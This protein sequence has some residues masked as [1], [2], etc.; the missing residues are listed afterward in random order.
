MDWTKATKDLSQPLDP[1]HVKPPA[2]GKYGNY[3][4]GWHAIAEANRIFGF[5][6]WSY[7]LDDLRPTN[8]TLTDGKHHVGYFARVTVT[9]DGTQRGDVGHGQGHGKS[10]GDAHDS[11]VK[12]AVTD[13]LKRALR[14]FGNPFGLALYDKSGANVRQP[15]PPQEVMDAIN[16][17]ETM[18]SLQTVWH[19]NR[20]WQSNPSFAAAKDT[21]KNE[22]QQK[23]AA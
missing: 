22:I 12:E 21:R 23:D 13:A 10:E 5:D 18:Q 20:E 7:T 11:A 17:A 16:G 1:K 19:A 2:P 15:D 14:S 4:E 6:G 3:I 9:V 8:A